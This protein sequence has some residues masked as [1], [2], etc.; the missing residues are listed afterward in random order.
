[1]KL[2]GERLRLGRDRGGP[3]PWRVLLY[4]VLIIAGLQLLRLQEKGEIAPLFLP[5]PGPTRTAASYAEEAE[6]H[7]SAG[8]LERAIDA[9]ETGANLDAGNADLWAE[10]ARI[11]VYSSDLLT[12]LE[13]RRARLAEARTA[14]ENAV[15]ANPDHVLAHA[16]RALVY[17]WSAAAELKDSIGI[18]DLV[19]VQAVVLESGE[20]SA[21]VIELADAV[22]PDAEGQALDDEATVIFTDAVQDVGTESWVIGGRTVEV[23]PRT[24]L[25]DENRRD[26]FLAEAETAATRALQLEP[27]NPLALAFHAEVLVDQQRF[28]QALDLA[29]QA[30]GDLS[31]LELKYRMDVH[32][33][34][35]TV[36]ENLGQYLQAIVEYQEAARINPN[37]T[38]LYL[39]IGVNYRQLREIDLALENFDKAA[40][41]NQQLGFE[42][43]TPYLAIGR[44]YVQDGEFF[45]A[46]INI[47][48][49]L[50]IDPSNPEIY[51]LLGSVYFQARNYESAIPVL[52]CA[53][54]GCS[55]EASAQLLCDLEIYFCDENGVILEDMPGQEIQ[56]VIGL[57]LGPGTLE[58]YYTY[59][60][61]LAA[62]DGHEDFPDACRDAE[63]IFQL[64]DANYRSDPI[65]V[66]IVAEGRAI[67]AAPGPAA[68]PT[69]LVTPGTDG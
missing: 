43:P 45:I 56:G 22:N 3:N 26:E 13:R 21:R 36:L 18:G 27:G 55:A 47:E 16:I 4:L 41:I 54:D 28:A 62:F 44:T 67:C 39:R 2:T 8:N 10:L 52:G 14:I 11:Q 32:R 24:L 40:K 12:T 42:D 34:Y 33:V 29:Q 23:T 5:T 60:S 30:A 65:V 50:R 66:A 9:L 49:A 17:D 19:R 48:S 37:L 58:Y 1:M 7:F 69:P 57:P 38:F 51:A 68:A 25:R 59:G 6:A 46:A 53:L 20:I 63:R 35:G 64:L 15:S 31:R 61:V